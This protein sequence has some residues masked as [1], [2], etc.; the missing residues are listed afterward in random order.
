MVILC[1]YT[2]A[3]SMSLITTATN[4]T[5]SIRFVCVCQKHNKNNSKSYAQIS[6]RFSTRTAYRTR[7]TRIN[8]CKFSDILGALYEQVVIRASLRTDRR[9]H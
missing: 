6:T 4:V 7:K 1:R 2:T 9:R 8:V 3:L 5:N